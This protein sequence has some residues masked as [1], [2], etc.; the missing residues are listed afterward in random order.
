MA[1]K[2]KK[3][4][5][6]QEK[7][8]EETIDQMGEALASGSYLLAV[9]SLNGNQINLH[10]KTVAFPT[11]YFRH[12]LDLLESDLTKE[13]DR[14]EIEDAPTTIDR[15]LDPNTEQEPGV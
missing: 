7:E 11:D 8:W 12:A 13:K 3:Q 6:A 10:R 15:T 4:K 5:T 9:F 1:K 2:K 14:I